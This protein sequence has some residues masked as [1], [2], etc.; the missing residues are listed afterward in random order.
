M[1]SGNSAQSQTAEGPVHGSEVVDVQ[2]A[3]YMTLAKACTYILLGHHVQDLYQQPVEIVRR[4]NCSFDLRRNTT[5]PAS[6]LRDTASAFTNTCPQAP[7]TAFSS[8]MD[9][10]LHSYAEH[11]RLAP[12]PLAESAA[13]PAPLSM[14]RSES[15]LGQGRLYLFQA[16]QDVYEINR[17]DP[18]VSRSEVF[19]VHQ[20][21]E[22]HGAWLAHLRETFGGMATGF[23]L[24]GEE[25][26]FYPE[27]P[28]WPISFCRPPSPP[29]MPPRGM[30]PRDYAP[31]VIKVPPVA[32]APEA[33]DLLPGL[34][35]ILAHRR[36]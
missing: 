24:G 3:G 12:M 2:G 14:A 35:G 8:Q 5:I 4:S 7:V 32:E 10:I 21:D 1:T 33:V 18:E 19:T 11:N 20:R 31:P 9:E 22:R 25:G 13:N 36:F 23:F 15:L 27:Y 16:A 30:L 34:G 17:T 6:S 29:P 26:M 28:Q